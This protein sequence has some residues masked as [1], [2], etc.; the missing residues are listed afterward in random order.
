MVNLLKALFEESMQLKSYIIQ[1][2]N[3]FMSRFSKVSIQNIFS[4]LCYV[5]YDELMIELILFSA[6][7]RLNNIL[8]NHYSRRE[9]MGM[10]T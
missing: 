2:Y 9:I 3:L 6:I 8:N 4:I 10:G 5:Y 1:F 7:E